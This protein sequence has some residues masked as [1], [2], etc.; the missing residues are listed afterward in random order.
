MLVV[1]E[2][3][4]QRT[5]DGNCW[6]N[7]IVDYSVFSR[8]LS[9]FNE[10]L[11]AIRVKD[12]VTKD[13]DFVHQCNGKNVHILPIPDYSG[14]SGYLKNI[15]EVMRLIMR[16]CNMADCAIIRTPSALSMQFIKVIHGK[17]P[18]VLEVSGD[19][20]K[21]MAP[22]EYK[23]PFR[24]FIRRLWT[25]SLK[26]DCMRANGVAYVTENVLQRSYPCRA[27]VEG[28]SKEYFTSHYSTV[29]IN[30][31]LIYEPKNYEKKTLFKL[32]HVAN[33]FTTFG[34]GHKEAIMVVKH[35]NDAGFDTHIDFIGDGPLKCEFKEFSRKHGVE[36]KVSF[37]GRLQNKEG[38]WNA[39]RAA[40]LFLFPS[41]S[42]GL[43]RVVIESM[44]VGTPCVSTN[45]G[46]I[47]EL[48][49]E[50]CISEVGDVKS[51]YKIVKGL[52]MNPAKMT[53]LSKKGIE[54]AKDYTE[55]V[56]QSRRTEFYKK[57]KY[58]C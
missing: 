42:E 15:Q 38:V 44:Y 56:L 23:S 45:V 50:E 19:P 25:I 30:D 41:H 55:S 17:I 1:N 48:L 2:C 24:P 58:I 3:H 12:V 28:D 54:K 6:S 20:W 51:M 49:Q 18:Y 13:A 43:P 57:L 8:P 16:Y 5:P 21:H 4:L 37:I 27:I 40:D 32:I 7:G 14:A 52:F 9:V 22:G 29:S 46:G 26:A 33:A 47:P 31:Q 34:K 35:L 10:V 11:I 39:L 53:E 36:N